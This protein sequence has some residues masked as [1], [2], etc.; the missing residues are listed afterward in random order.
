MGLG[1]ALTDIQYSQ[2]MFNTMDS[3]VNY[4][5]GMREVVLVT[6]EPSAP[7][8]TL[9]KD[10]ASQDDSYITPAPAINAMNLLS[11]YS[12][13]LHKDDFDITSLALDNRRLSLFNLVVSQRALPQIWISS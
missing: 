6:D 5:I 13:Y 7:Q 3:P 4:P 8:R 2:T 11:L 12:P 9:P 1:C 10:F